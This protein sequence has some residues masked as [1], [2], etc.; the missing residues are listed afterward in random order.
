[1][2]QRDRGEVE[3]AAERRIVLE[4]VD[5][6]VRAAAR[7]YLAGRALDSTRT[8]QPASRSAAISLKTKVSERAG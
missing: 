3:Q 6:P 1:M 5:P 7:S 2:A 8:L 4:V